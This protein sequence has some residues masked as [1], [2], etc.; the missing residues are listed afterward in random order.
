V[1]IAHVCNSNTSIAKQMMPL[2]VNEGPESKDQ[3]SLR[4]GQAKA[5]GRTQEKC[6]TLGHQ[7]IR[8]INSNHS[9][10]SPA[11]PKMTFYLSEND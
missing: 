9:K 11:P 1:C 10:V 6:S 3:E 5:R 4:R 8:D 2:S 7:V